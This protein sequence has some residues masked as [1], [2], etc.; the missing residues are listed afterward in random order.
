MAAISSLRVS[1]ET[2]PTAP[3]GDESEAANPV[4]VHIR[5]RP[6]GSIGHISN[7]PPLLSEDDWFKLLCSAIGQKYLTRAGGRGFFRTTRFELESISARK[8]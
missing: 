6:D 1:A 8:P 4:L 2:S 5:F 7:L 3:K